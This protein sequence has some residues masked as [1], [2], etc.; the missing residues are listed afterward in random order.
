[1][2]K[3]NQR[4]FSKS[5]VAVKGARPESPLPRELNPTLPGVPVFTVVVAMEMELLVVVDGI[6]LALFM[7]DGKEHKVV[8]VSTS[9]V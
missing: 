4:N 1:M 7:T 5:D 6:L 3:N 9:C 8:T 2:S